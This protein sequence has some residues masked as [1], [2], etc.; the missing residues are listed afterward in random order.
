MDAE[1][2]ARLLVVEDESFIADALSASLRFRGFPVQV[3]GTGQDA[4]SIIARE[5]PD[6]VLL[7]VVLPDIDGFTLTRQ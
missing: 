5:T 2:S 1:T 6:L 3:A 4:L 7:D